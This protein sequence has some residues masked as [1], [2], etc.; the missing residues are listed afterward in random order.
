[1]IGSLESSLS[2]VKK[3]RET[4][5]ANP[6][7]STAFELTESWGFV[8]KQSSTS[9]A[10]SDTV[11]GKERRRG[12]FLGSRLGVPRPSVTDVSEESID[13]ESATGS[14]PRKVMSDASLNSGTAQSAESASTSL[15]FKIDLNVTIASGSCLLLPVNVADL[16]EDQRRQ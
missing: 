14:L 5:D 16:P 15:A 3:A 4:A 7:P 10:Q 1:M 9:Q 6:T 11:D 2:I 12:A 13:G 8:L